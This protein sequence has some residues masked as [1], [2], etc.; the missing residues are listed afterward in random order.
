VSFDQTLERMDERL[1]RV[2][3]QSPY[4]QVKRGG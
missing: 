1:R 2:E 4:I 3:Q